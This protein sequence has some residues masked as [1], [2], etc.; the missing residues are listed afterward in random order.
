MDSKIIDGRKIAKDHEEQLKQKVASLGIKPSIVSILV[1][2]DP[3]SVLYSDI[4][5]KKAQE[6]GIDFNL[7]EFA[8]PSSTWD[9]VC[10][11]IK[12]LNQDEQVN[13]I[14]VQMPLPQQFL[15][16]HTEG[17]LVNIIDSKKDVDGLRNDSPYLHATARAVMT[18]LENEGI[19]VMQKKVAVVGATGMVGTPLVRALKSRG[20][21]VIEINKQTDSLTELTSQ[22]DILISAVGQ[23]GLI[24][25]DQIKMGAVVIDVGMDV[26]FEAVL[27]KV[28]KITP[29]K[30]GVGPVTVISLLENVVKSVIKGE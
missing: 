24:G 16:S 19:D 22:A 25:P 13:G 28:S 18:I 1:G 21:I 23:Q 7:K 17:E 15:D 12:R 29:P 2:D 11:E 10:E 14:M 30:G 26:D 27:P 8:L 6:V 20:A 9:D 4:K 5:M 3:S